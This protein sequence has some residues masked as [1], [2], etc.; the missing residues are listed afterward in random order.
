MRKFVAQG[1]LR[2][3]KV[4]RVYY[5]PASE[6]TDFIKRNIT[7]RPDDDGAESN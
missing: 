1:R 3:V 4:G 2:H 6:I 7:P 5:I